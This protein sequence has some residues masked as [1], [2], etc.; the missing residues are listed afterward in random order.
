VEQVAPGATWS[1]I[2]GQHI[3]ELATEERSKG[4]GTFG[5]CS[6]VRQVWVER[7]DHPPTSEDQELTPLC[8][9]LLVQAWSMG[10]ERTCLECKPVSFPTEVDLDLFAISDVDTLV[11]CP[12]P[13]TGGVQPA[14]NLSFDATAMTHSCASSR[15]EFEKEFAAVNRA[16]RQRLNECA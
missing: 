6:L 14:S 13:Q 9:A 12:T 16:V 15:Y 7:F 3:V 8:I 2:C 10:S 1:T 5:K 4:G 11:R